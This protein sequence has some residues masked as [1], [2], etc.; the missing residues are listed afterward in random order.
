MFTWSAWV[1][2]AQNDYLHNAEDVHHSPQFSQ[3][4]PNTGEIKLRKKIAGVIFA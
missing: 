3:C 2:N 1:K 4:F